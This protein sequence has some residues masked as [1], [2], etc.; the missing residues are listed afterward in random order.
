MIEL[1]DVPETMLGFRATGDVDRQEFRNVVL[2]PV[3]RLIRERKALNFLL[4][5]E[6][7]FTVPRDDFWMHDALINGYRKLS[8]WNRAAI[9]TDLAAVNN[10]ARAFR[11]FARGELRSFATA[12]LMRAVAWTAG[13]DRAI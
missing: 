8:A 13:G 3:C 11:I 2:P 10:F 7:P 9:V 1:M 6:P 5:L 4:L 12:E